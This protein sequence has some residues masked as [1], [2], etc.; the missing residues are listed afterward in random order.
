MTLAREAVRLNTTVYGSATA[1]PFSGLEESI[2]PD[3]ERTVIQHE[4]PLSVYWPV[5]DLGPIPPS[6]RGR[7]LLYETAVHAFI[8]DVG[9]AAAERKFYWTDSGVEVYAWVRSG[10]ANRERWADGLASYWQWVTFEF[11][12]TRTAVYRASDDAVLW[13]GS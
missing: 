2:L 5:K 8:A 4:V 12:S 10:S 13:G 6:I 1:D 9:S 11:V 7:I 3:S